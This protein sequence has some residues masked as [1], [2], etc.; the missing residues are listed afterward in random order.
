M[1]RVRPTEHGLQV[2]TPELD[3]ITFAPIEGEG[4]RIR[5]AES[6]LHEKTRDKHI[7]I[8]GRDNVREVGEWMQT[9]P[10]ESDSDFRQLDHDFAIDSSDPKKHLA[11]IALKRI[12]LDSDGEIDMD[13]LALIDPE[14]AETIKTVSEIDVLAGNLTDALSFL[15]SHREP[16]KREGFDF[17]YEPNLQP[18]YSNV[19]LATQK[20]D[21]LSLYVDGLRHFEAIPFAAMHQLGEWVLDGYQTVENKSVWN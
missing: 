19:L 4:V 14:L 9:L 2:S 11:A 12:P 7:L 10:A 20:Y 1:Q 16:E 17:A 8:Q 18:G 5:L 3:V 13:E 6:I 21:N 15:F